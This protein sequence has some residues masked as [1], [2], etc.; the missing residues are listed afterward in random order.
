MLTEIQ[1]MVTHVADR[2]GPATVGVGTRW[3]RG[4]GLVIAPDRVLTNAHNA[5]RGEVGVVFPD[6]R[7]TTGS[8][9]AADIDAELSVI[10]VDTDGATP[11]EFA[12]EAPGLGA[13]VVALA[14]PGGRGLHAAPG[15]VSA[16]ERSFRGPRG[17]RV[18][19]AVE[20]TAPMVR[21]SS[22]GPLLAPDGRLLGVNT[23]RL[24]GGLYLAL[25]ATEELQGSVD[26]L[27][28]GEHVPRR[29]LGVAV[30][31][32]KAARRMRAAVGLDDRTGLLV[33]EVAPEGPA[34]RAGIRRGDLIV[35]VAGEEISGVDDLQD[36]LD[37]HDPE[38]GLSLR[39]VRGSEEL[40]VVVGFGTDVAEEGRA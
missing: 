38:A 36:H 39:V 28:R 32:P 16:T 25:P 30:A 3:G 33:R 20:H 34:G 12:D 7:Q 22:G 17:R 15:F 21:G 1:Q 8:V 40:E 11:V 26:S 14:N 37:A 27:A 13:A 18:D 35:A 23:H 9:A 29:R 2:V 5:L 10:E 31:P 19:G 24:E 6:G 4:S